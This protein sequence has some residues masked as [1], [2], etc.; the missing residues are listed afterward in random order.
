MVRHRSEDEG[1]RDQR[2]TLA[3]VLV[4]HREG[5]PWPAIGPRTMA[6]EAPPRT[7]GV[8]EEVERAA[9]GPGAEG[10][11]IGFLVPVARAARRAFA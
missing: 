3:R 6:S 2:Q 11:G 5:E 1:E 4:D 9:L 7:E 8:G 10:T